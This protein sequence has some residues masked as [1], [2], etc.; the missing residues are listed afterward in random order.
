MAASFPLYL[1]PDARRL[2]QS[3]SLLHRFAQMAH[4]HEGSSLLELH[5]SAAG[6]A[7]AQ[8]LDCHLTVVEPEAKVVESLRE[9]ARVAGVEGKVG[10]QVGDGVK[11]PF[12]ERAFDG[13]FSF[14]RVLGLPHEVAKAWRPYLAEMGRAGFTAVVKVSRTP[15]PE[16][17][18]YWEQRLGAPLMLPREAL[19]AVE[20]EGFEPELIETA[21]EGEFEEYLR[22]LEGALSRQPAS[23]EPGPAALKAEL[24]LHQSL[25][26]RTGVTLAFV[27][28][29]RKEPGEK[30]P[31][32]RDGG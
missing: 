12:A 28:A 23:D 6:L 25:Q 26:G 15:A 17:L 32:S 30:P 4:W 21:G 29:R 8:T 20:R 13:I 22:E 24:A 18:A 1:P 16:A 27:V 14:G 7:L 31:P 10:F 11:L 2:F 5:G 19:M 3:E 9:R